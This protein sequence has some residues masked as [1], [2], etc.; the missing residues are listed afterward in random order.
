[1]SFVKCFDAVNMVLE[2]ATERFYP[3]W[4]PDA[5]RTEQLRQYCEAIDAVVDEYGGTYFEVE[6]DEETMRIHVKLVCQE[7]TLQRDKLLP[8]IQRSVFTR[9]VNRENDALAIHFAFAGIW[10]HNTYWR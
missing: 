6:V 7:I 3:L 4:S 5:H 10:H 9:I 1:M 8:V 2:E